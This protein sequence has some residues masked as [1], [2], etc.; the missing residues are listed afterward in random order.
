MC[1]RWYKCNL[2]SPTSYTSGANHLYGYKNGLKLK[3]L[4]WDLLSKLLPVPT[5]YSSRKTVLLCSAP[6][7]KGACKINITSNSDHLFKS[8][9]NCCRYKYMILIFGLI[10]HDVLILRF[11]QENG[12]VL[13]CTLPLKHIVFFD[14]PKHKN[15]TAASNIILTS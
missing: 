3:G 1:I 13:L 12:I 14:D 5:A 7:V 4:V 11:L 2:A 10:E 9:A 6:K 15:R 8:L